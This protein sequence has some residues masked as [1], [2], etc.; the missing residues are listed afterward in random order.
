[1][2][3][4]TQNKATSAHEASLA[5]RARQAASGAQAKVSAATSATTGAVKDHPY[6][7]AGIVAG[8]AAAIGGAAC[9]ASR[10]NAEQG[11]GSTKH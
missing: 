11:H 9:A 3:N 1:M 10:R 2:T 5:E 4:A 8:V 6:A 7:T